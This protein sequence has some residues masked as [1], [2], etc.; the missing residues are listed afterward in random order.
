MSKQR[1][2][3]LRNKIQYCSLNMLWMLKSLNTYLKKGREKRRTGMK[4]EEC[5][6]G[7]E[8]GE[9]EMR[10]GVRERKRDRKREGGTD[11]GRVICVWEFV[12]VR[13]RDG[14]RERGEG[15]GGRERVIEREGGRDREINRS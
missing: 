8:R 4:L 1:I 14:E 7:G 15:E 9:T 13:K 2:P 6:R 10:E 5:W 11:R 12:C 3:H